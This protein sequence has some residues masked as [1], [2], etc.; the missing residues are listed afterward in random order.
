MSEQE[1]EQ[2]SEPGTEE[3]AETLEDLDVAE[4]DAEDVKGG[5]VVILE[6]H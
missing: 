3:S 6:R 4:D 5:G 2:Q 1:H